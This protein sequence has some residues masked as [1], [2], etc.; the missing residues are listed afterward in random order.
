MEKSMALENFFSMMATFM[1]VSGSLIED[2]DEESLFG[3]VCKKALQNTM[4]VN[5]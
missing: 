2:M 1:K 5:G 4:M 3:I